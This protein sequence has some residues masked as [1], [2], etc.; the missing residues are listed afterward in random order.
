MLEYIKFCLVDFWF[1]FNCIKILFKRKLEKKNME[2]KGSTLY[3]PS[4]P[5]PVSSHPRDPAF[6]APAQF[7]AAQQRR[8][9]PS[10]L[11]LGPLTAGTPRFSG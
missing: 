9:A 7:A 6:P 5:N 1:E 10:P 3:F 4:R 11:S 8:R 2:K